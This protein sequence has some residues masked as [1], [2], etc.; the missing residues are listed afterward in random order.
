MD[1]VGITTLM[2]SLPTPDSMKFSPI[3]TVPSKSPNNFDPR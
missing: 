3:Y 2:G 1:W